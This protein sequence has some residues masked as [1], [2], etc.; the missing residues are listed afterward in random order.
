MHWFIGSRG[1]SS[2]ERRQVTLISWEAEHPEQQIGRALYACTG[3]VKDD[4]GRWVDPTYLSWADHLP[5]LPF[6]YSSWDLYVQGLMH[7]TSSYLNRYLS[8]KS[9]CFSVPFWTPTRVSIAW[10]LLLPP[11]LLAPDKVS[12]VLNLF[13]KCCSLPYLNWVL[14]FPQGAL[15]PS[16]LVHD[17]RNDFILFPFQSLLL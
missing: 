3:S 9:L 1:F 2:L 7:S 13:L 14:V 10:L 5:I 12:Y 8:H 6:P 16:L 15:F 11:V 4:Q 17:T